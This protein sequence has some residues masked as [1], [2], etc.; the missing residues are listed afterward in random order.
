MLEN[1]KVEIG[2]TYKHFKG[3]LHKVILIAKD[4][5]SLEDM[6]VYTHEEDGSIWVRTEKMF[7]SKVDKTKYPEVEQEYRFEL[8]K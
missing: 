8:L 4:S 6:V 5:E 1:R 7:L 3:T 2:K